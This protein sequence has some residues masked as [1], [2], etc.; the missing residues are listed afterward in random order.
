MWSEFA[1]GAK[2]TL[3]TVAVLNAD[4]VRSAPFLLPNSDEF[5]CKIRLTREWRYWW[6]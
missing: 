6:D 5:R 3:D 2:S 4:T 1:S